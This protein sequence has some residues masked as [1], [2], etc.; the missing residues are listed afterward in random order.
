MGC[1]VLSLSRKLLKMNLSISENQ[2][3]EPIKYF[4]CPALLWIAV[5]GPGMQLSVQIL[6]P[7][8]GVARNLLYGYVTYVKILRQK[9]GILRQKRIVASM[10]GRTRFMLYL[11]NH[12][13]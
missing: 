8:N 2:Q 10:L 4:L 7:S 3:N 9:K 11:R 1:V 12:H 5:G 13:A 6:A